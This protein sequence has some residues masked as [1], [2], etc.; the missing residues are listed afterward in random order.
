[1]SLARHRGD[2]EQTLGRFASG[3]ILVTLDRG[4]YWQC[5]YIIPKDGFDAIKATGLPAFREEIAAVAPFLRERTAAWKDWS[6][7]KMLS[8]RVDHLRNWSRP[9]LL[10]IGDSA[11]AMSPVGGVGINLAV[12]DAVAAA[13]LLWQ[14]LLH[15]AANHATLDGLLAR[16]QKRREF[17]TRMTQSFQVFA[18]K[19]FIFPALAHKL[20]VS[21][22]PLP[23]KLLKAF[24]ILR[25]IPARMLGVGI[26]PEHI[27]T[28]AQRRAQ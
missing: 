24:P 3:R 12:Q 7:I 5:A 2:P 10:C 13:N 1:M 22:L 8:V 11:H 9:G 15:R 25:R 16:L 17:P 18:H 26:R 28:P 27:H 21:K 14:P 23:L 20:R 6:D 4:D 19:R